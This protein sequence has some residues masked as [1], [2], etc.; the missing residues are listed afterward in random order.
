MPFCGWLLRRC[1]SKKEHPQ[2]TQSW[3]TAF[4]SLLN[5]SHH[6]LQ[7]LPHS[8]QFTLL[9]SQITLF[10]QDN[11][12]LMDSH[13]SLS[14][15]VEDFLN[16]HQRCTPP[17]PGGAPTTFRV[18]LSPLSDHLRRQLHHLHHNTPKTIHVHSHSA[19]L[20]FALPH[21]ALGSPSQIAFCA[22]TPPTPNTCFVRPSTTPA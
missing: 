6:F 22:P 11:N 9:P 4:C 5:G 16:G 14:P 1:T 3:L 7:S 19:H 15:L 17:F 21:Q 8:I 10:P 12:F 2:A 20:F 13:T 18:P